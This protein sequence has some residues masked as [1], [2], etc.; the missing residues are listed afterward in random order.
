[1]LSDELLNKETDI[2]TEVAPLLILDSKSA[3]CIDSLY[4]ILGQWASSSLYTH[5][6]EFGR[7]YAY[8]T[9]MRILGS[10]TIK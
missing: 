9:G 10:Y 1:M 6:W 7:L 5:Q 4:R 2:F 8:S 3:V